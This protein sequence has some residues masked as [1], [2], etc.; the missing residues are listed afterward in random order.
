[1]MACAM[2]SLRVITSPLLSNPTILLQ[3]KR[4]AN[5]LP[6]KRLVQVGDNVRGTFQANREPEQRL[7]RA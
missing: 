5:A 7:R 4:L 2:V 3:D 6:P 1:M